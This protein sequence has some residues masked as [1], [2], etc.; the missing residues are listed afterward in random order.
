[1]PLSRLR[2]RLTM[3][4]PCHRCATVRPCRAGR[5]A[6]SPS[7]SGDDLHGAGRVYSRDT[8]P[9]ENNSGARRQRSSIAI[10][11][12]LPVQTPAWDTLGSGKPPRGHAA[13][14]V[15]QEGEDE[16]RGADPRHKI[17][18]TGRGL[19]CESRVT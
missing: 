4:R 3:A 19:R 1:P 15:D 7:E 2:D 10:V 13:V 6:S 8:S 9:A 12:D 11:T 14:A 5:A 16:G 18:P 17:R